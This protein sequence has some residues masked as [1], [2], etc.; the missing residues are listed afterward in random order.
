MHFV[1]ES[2]LKFHLISS[3]VG[4]T[5]HSAY[6]MTKRKQR[7]LAEQAQESTRNMWLLYSNAFECFLFDLR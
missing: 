2:A 5:Q 4:L 1:A 7:S 6:E 3:N